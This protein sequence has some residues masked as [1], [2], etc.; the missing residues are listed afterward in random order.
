[1]D[2]YDLAMIQEAFEESML[3]FHVDLIDWHRISADFKRH[4]EMGYEVFEY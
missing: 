3:P 2:L 1:M 4:I